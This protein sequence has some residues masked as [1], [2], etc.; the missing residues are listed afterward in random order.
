M[1]VVLLQ[2]VNKLGRAGDVKTVA[3]GYAK[4]YLIPRGLAIQATE[5][6]VKVA[7]LQK[8]AVAARQAR[9]ESE[10][11]ELAS[12]L[13][14]KEVEVVVKAGPKDRIYGAVTSADIAKALKKATG[15]DVDK[16]RIELEKPIHELGTFNATVK[17]SAEHSPNVKVV[18]KGE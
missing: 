2:D 16:K 15:Y 10:I 7:E 12:Q 3:D 18:V 14:G 8:K 5:G 4:N 13:E 9:T 17:L 6:S 1:K 11:A